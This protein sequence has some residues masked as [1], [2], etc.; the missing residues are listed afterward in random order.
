MP[1]RPMIG[2]ANKVGILADLLRPIV[3][4]IDGNED[5]VE[6]LVIGGLAPELNQSR[7]GRRANVTATGE[8]E[9]EGVRLAF[10]RL[11]QNGLPSASIRVND[12]PKLAFTGP[13]VACSRWRIA[14]RP[15]GTGRGPQSL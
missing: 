4:R 8:T 5:D 7:Q 12:P 9:I 1:V 13:E 6:C 15:P 14:S 2:A 10:E 11:A 3:R